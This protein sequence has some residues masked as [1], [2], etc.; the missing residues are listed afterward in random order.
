MEATLTPALS[1][2]GEGARKRDTS[3]GVEHGTGAGNASGVV[4]GVPRQGDR[5]GRPYERRTRRGEE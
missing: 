1:L 2:E 5:E 3:E 4:L